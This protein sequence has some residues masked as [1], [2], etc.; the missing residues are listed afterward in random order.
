MLVELLALLGLKGITG[1]GRA[2]D[3]A[4]S[5]RDTAKLDANGNVTCFG[6]TGK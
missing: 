4:K 5:K 6:R 2:V 1:I 3:D